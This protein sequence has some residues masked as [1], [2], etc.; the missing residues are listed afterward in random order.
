MVTWVLL[1]FIAGSSDRTN[2]LFGLSY[3]E[4]IWF[5]RV[6]VFVGP[7]LAALIAYRACKELT[8][9]ELVAADRH[10]AEEEARLARTSLEAEQ[11]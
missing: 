4:Q 6:L 5:Y 10:R 1:V 9:G 3:T 2:I 7:A 8:A 11:P